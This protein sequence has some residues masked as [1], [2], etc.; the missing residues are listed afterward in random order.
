MTTSHNLT[1]LEICRSLVRCPSVTPEQEGALDLIESLLTDAG[2]RCSRQTFSAGGT[3][4]V[5]NL[6]AEIGAGSPHLSFAGHVD[7]VPTG[8]EKLW[9]H[10]PFDAVIEDGKL[11]GRGTADM[12]GAVACF[13]AAAIDHIAEGTYERG[14][15]SFIITCDE[16]GL[17]I[18]GTRKLLDWM[19][20]QGHQ[21]DF[22]ILGEPSNDQNIGEA[23]KIGRRGSLNATLVVEGKQGHVA[24]QHLAE[25][26]VPAILSALSGLVSWEIDQ[27][28]QY[29]APSN[30]EISTIDV[31]NT[32]ENVIPG[33]VSSKFNIRFNDGH[34]SDSLKNSIEKM[35]A[36]RLSPF[37]LK[38]DLTFRVTGE[39][40]L[41]ETN[42]TVS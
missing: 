36:D 38:Y 5:E 7:V 33:L 41:C 15:L 2:F 11:Y 9:S 22:C 20:A 40:F 34:T 8:D 6:Y 23:I 16:E 13:L 27:G 17:A 25:N 18:N 30:L 26:P 3:P 12:K 35:V 1:A 42:E 21:P 32:A 31:G 19:T 24:Y 39:S 10:P 28:T 14:T 29:F 4:D 37:G